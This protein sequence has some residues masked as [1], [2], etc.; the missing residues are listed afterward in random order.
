MKKNKSFGKEAERRAKIYLQNLGYEFIKQN[1]RSKDG[2][3]D[4]IFKDEA[5]LVFVEVK[6]RSDERF[7]EIEST[8]DK[9]K[10]K[11]IL[12]TAENYIENSTVQFDETRIDAIFIIQRDDKWELK[13]I[14]NFF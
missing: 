1:Y 14:K 12:K 13:H 2:E 7:M 11:K 6:A 10:I 5:I 9:K 8:I 4:I 3:I